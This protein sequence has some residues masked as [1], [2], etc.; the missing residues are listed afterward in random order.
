MVHPEILQAE[1]LGGRADSQGYRCI[2][3]DCEVN[4]EDVYIDLFGR[5]FCDKK[6]KEVYYGKH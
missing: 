3:C 5:S 4:E 1:R 6:C 2:C